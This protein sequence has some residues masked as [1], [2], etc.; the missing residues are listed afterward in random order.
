MKALR[1]VNPKITDD[2]RFQRVSSA[3]CKVTVGQYEQ[4]PKE[5][6]EDQDHHGVFIAYEGAEI[7]GLMTIMLGSIPQWVL[8]Y[9]DTSEAK[10]A[11]IGLG[12]DFL[13]GLG[14]TRFVAVNT[15]GAADS[16]WKRAF[17]RKGEASKIGTIMEFKL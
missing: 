14:Y 15:S 2:P 9:A 4:V 10:R 12:V 1:V 13:K 16:V 6:I 8:F 7:L 5:W 11:L 17:W 3:A